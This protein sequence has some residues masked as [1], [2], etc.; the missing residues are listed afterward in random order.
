MHRDWLHFFFAL[1][2]HTVQLWRRLGLDEVDGWVV[3][4]HVLSF[5][6]PH[7]SSSSL[8]D[9][10]YHVAL[11]GGDIARASVDGD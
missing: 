9:F 4:H 6:P 11:S 2:F 7:R 5:P 10:Y 8:M 3:L 1:P